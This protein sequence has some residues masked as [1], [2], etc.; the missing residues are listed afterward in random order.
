MT[1]YAS[2]GWGFKPDFDKTVRRSAPA[3]ILPPGVNVPSLPRTRP[4]RA[5]IFD[6]APHR[7]RGVG[8]AP[9][10]SPGMMNRCIALC[11]EFGM[12]RHIAEEARTNPFGPRHSVYFL[13]ALIMDANRGDKE[14]KAAL[15]RVREGLR[16]AGAISEMFAA[17]EQPADSGEL[18]RLLG[19]D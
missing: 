7:N 12:P 9:E 17:K 1:G 3:I 18:T 14:A 13:A 6:P 11:V 16:N 15:D 10:S 5:P 4:A 19:A 2:A 8:R